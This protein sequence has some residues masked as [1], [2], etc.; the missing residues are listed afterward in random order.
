MRDPRRQRGVAVR[1]QRLRHPGVQRRA[2]G[3]RQPVQHGLPRQR[4]HEPVAVGGAGHRFDEAHRDR[5]VDRVH[6]RAPV[7]RAG[8]DQRRQVEPVADHRGQL[9]GLPQLRPEARQPGRH[10]VAER[11]RHPLRAAQGGD[12]AAAFQVEPGLPEEERVAAGPVAQDRR[13]GPRRGRRHARVVAHELGDGLGVEPGEVEAAHAVEP[14]QVGQPGAELVRPVR[15]G[16]PE[17]GHHQRR[18]VQAGVDHVLEQRDGR[19]LRPVQVV[20][21]DDQRP[22]AGDRPE[23]PGDGLEQVAAAVADR[24]GRVREVACGVPGQQAELPGDVQRAGLA[25][26]EQVVQHLDERLVGHAGVLRRRAHQHG[27]ALLRAARRRPRRPAGSCP[28]RARRRP[29]GPGRLPAPRVP[30]RS[31]GPRARSGGRRAGSGARRRT[32][33]A[34]RPGST[35]PY[36]ARYCAPPVRSIVRSD[37]PPARCEG[38]ASVMTRRWPRRAS[39]PAT[40]CEG[41]VT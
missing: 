36:P 41:A 40:L 18:G 28:H 22:V 13:G 32:G 12:T 2:A 37:P 30:T 11:G 1:L 5:G 7:G 39:S 35:A 19:Q 8:P 15:R 24:L 6:A 21:D 20:E 27:D 16:G 25:R 3:V 17:G 31:P 10:R 23:Q 29:A 38:S 33:A 4:V 14:V 34:G 9:D 26:Q